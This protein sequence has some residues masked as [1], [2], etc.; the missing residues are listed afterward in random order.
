MKK[1]GGERRES[2]FETV[3]GDPQVDISKHDVFLY[4]GRREKVKTE[5]RKLRWGA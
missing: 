1:K 5:K 2:T 4:I 3:G